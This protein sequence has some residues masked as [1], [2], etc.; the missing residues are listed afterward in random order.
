MSWH[1]ARVTK[2]EITHNFTAPGKILCGAK[3]SGEN[4]SGRKEPLCR[5]RSAREVCA[6]SP[7]ASRGAS[8]GLIVHAKAYGHPRR[9]PGFRAAVNP[10]R[11]QSADLDA[12]RSIGT[13]V[14]KRGSG[15][16][17]DAGAA[18][19]RASG[20]AGGFGNMGAMVGGGRGAGSDPRSPALAGGVARI[21]RDRA[22]R[23]RRRNLPGRI[24]G[25]RRVARRAA[26]EAAAEGPGD[27]LRPIDRTSGL[28]TP[29]RGRVS[30][31]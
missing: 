18:V 4:S 9:P 20:G 21:R 17:S 19:S 30:H 27:P 2:T 8:R 7:L 26:R 11:S 3:L 12:H 1:K 23:G 29:R 16:V 6:G 15:W 14:G 22:R 10:A 31:R 13:T 5:A 25:G 24:A 28:R